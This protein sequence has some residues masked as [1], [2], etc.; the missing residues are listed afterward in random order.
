MSTNRYHPDVLLRTHSFESENYHI[1]AT[2]NLIF[3]H[4]VQQSCIRH[5]CHCM[6]VKSLISFFSDSFSP[7]AEWSA[8]RPS[9]CPSPG[10]SF[11]FRRRT[12]ISRCN[13]RRFEFQ[14]CDPCAPITPA[15]TTTTTT[16]TT[17]P[18]TTQSTGT[19]LMSP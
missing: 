16:T 19:L 2:S 11:R 5:I 12:C 13:G 6:F 14:A 9:S 15:V 8:C 17:T 1:A 4:H 10:N 18:T 3:L 7:W